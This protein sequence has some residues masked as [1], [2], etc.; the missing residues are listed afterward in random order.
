MITLT[1][2]LVFGI[3]TR[4]K[5]EYCIVNLKTQSTSANLHN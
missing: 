5:L 1:S 2:D 3:E 4:R